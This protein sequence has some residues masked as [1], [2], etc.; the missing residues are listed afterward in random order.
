SLLDGKTT[1]SEALG[2]IAKSNP[3]AALSEHEATSVCNWLI[4]NGLVHTFG[5][6]GLNEPELSLPKTAEAPSWAGWNP[7]IYRV[8]LLHPDRFFEKMAP[9]VGWLFTSWVFIFWLALGLAAAYCIWSDWSRFLLSFNGVFAPM[10]WLWLPLCWLVLKLVHE[11]A[12]GLA[13]KTQGG[14]VR[15][16]GAIF[17]LFV[18][19]T[20]VDV[21]SSWRFRWK[22][23][24]ILTAAAGMYFELLVA[25]LAVLLWSATGPGLVN[26][27][28]FNVILMASVTTLLFNANFLMKFDGYYILSDLLEIPN[29]QIVARQYVYACLTRPFHDPD[30]PSRSLP[31]SRLQ[32]AFIFCYGVAAFCWKI[33]VCACMIIAASTFFH[34]AGVILALA[35]IFLW[36]GMPTIRFLKRN[37]YSKKRQHGT[38]RFSFPSLGVA[39][40]LAVL[41]VTVVPWPCPTRAPAVVQYAPLAV[42]RADS[43]GFVSEIH[44]RAGQSVKKDQILATLRNDELHKDLADIKL[45]VKQAE[46]KIR[47]YE[48]QREMASVQAEMKNLES[49]QSKLQ[50]KQLQV[51][52]L[53]IRSPIAGTVIADENLAMLKGVY[54]QPGEEILAIGDEESKELQLAISEQDLTSFREV[55][56]TSLRIRLPGGH[57]FK[58]DL[59]SIMPRASLQCPHEALSANNGGPLGV[60]ASTSNAENDVN[61]GQ[62]LDLLSPHFIGTIELTGSQSLELKAG[63][64]GVVSI[65][66]DYKS[67]G[68]QVYRIVTRWVREKFRQSAAK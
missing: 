34:G 39:I 56:G 19:V 57:L 17:I 62:E 66:S 33:V 53:T 30:P 61:S 5:V 32:R 60:R 36:L 68:T 16:A 58:A 14:S 31:S 43:P 45:S 26:N 15:E 35:A 12:H 2:L 9:Y 7:L 4:D 24:R 20:Y 63:Q 3:N 64:V 46:V 54:M 10:N 59:S 52:Q 55:V 50:D 13:C 18:P 51:D 22:W 38:R 23:Q 47:V 6:A 49:L 11:F 67:I 29:L 28:C 65:Y 44:V 42:I 8:P 25:G 41:L 37:F 21:T 48:H 40:F 27:L 1:L